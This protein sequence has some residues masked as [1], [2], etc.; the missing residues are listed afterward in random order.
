MVARKHSDEEMKEA[1]KGRTVAEAAK[2][3]V[4]M[5]ATCTRTRPGLRARA[6]AQ[7]MT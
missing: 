5:S 2:L 4:C 1:L 6:G 3:L 7:S